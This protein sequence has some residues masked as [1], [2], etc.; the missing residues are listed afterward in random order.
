MSYRWRTLSLFGYCRRSSLLP[1][2]LTLAR[3]GFRMRV[4]ACTHDHDAI[5]AGGG[6]VF[7][8]PAAAQIQKGTPVCMARAHCSALLRL[9]GLGKSRVRAV[10]QPPFSRY[11]L[12][13][14]LVFPL[15]F[16][17]FY[18]AT[19]SPVQLCTPSL[20][21]THRL[22][23]TPSTFPSPFTKCFAREICLRPFSS[24]WSC[25]ARSKRCPHLT[26]MPSSTP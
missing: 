10:F 20:C 7:P 25:S 15:F 3:A 4:L 23:D 22:A 21:A 16:F 8:L 1:S 24:T 5:R 17:L 11:F 6:R 26:C 2:P 14:L 9:F 12:P 19:F 18:P 13:S